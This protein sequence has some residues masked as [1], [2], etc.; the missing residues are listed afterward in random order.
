[1]VGSLAEGD[2]DRHSGDSRRKA[3]RQAEG[4]PEHSGTVEKQAQHRRAHGGRKGGPSYAKGYIGEEAAR[5]TDADAEPTA[6]PAETA[7]VS[8]APSDAVC[9]G[10][11]ILKQ[12]REIG[13]D[14]E[15]SEDV[16]GQLGYTTGTGTPIALRTHR[17]VARRGK[18][19][20]P[21]P[22]R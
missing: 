18:M 15:L 6:R 1:M 7:A 16:N 9:T 4:V 3:D 21:Y 20:T 8:G 2:V 11:L 17:A 5:A 13:D 14:R 10:G 19:W 12:A 22:C